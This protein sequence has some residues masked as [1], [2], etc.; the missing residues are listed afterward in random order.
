MKT[1]SQKIEEIASHEWIKVWTTKYSFLDVYQF[2]PGYTNQAYKNTGKG[3]DHILFNY[4]NGLAT[5][6]RIVSELKELSTFY[7]SMAVEDISYLEN[8]IQKMYEVIESI[9]SNYSKK[10]LFES[11]DTFKKLRDDLVNF[12]PYYL[13]M[14]WTPDGLKEMKIEDSAKEKITNLCL[15]ARHKTE[16]FYLNLEKF[17]TT[18]YELLDKEEQLGYGEYILALT[19]D[20]IEEYIN[21][22]KIVEKSILIERWNGAMLAGDGNVID[23]FTGKDA[24]LLLSKVESFDKALKEVKGTVAMKGIVRGVV[25]VIFKDE[26]M[27]KFNEGD[28]LI[29]T[30]TRP[31]WVPVMK[32]SGAFVTDAGGMLCHAAIV[33]RELGRPCVIG[34]KIATQVFKD[35]DM[36]EVDAERG[37]I[38]II[39]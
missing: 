33:A 32:K 21:N 12:L 7:A 18:S 25:K 31:E 22:K 8:S 14:L 34:T 37:L 17:V 35:G 11:I 30:M 26:D 24:E 5:V 13:V 2:V 4:K 6:Y 10:S 38:K 27:A 16:H 36:V 1:N 28:I 23:L 15:D 3:F 9:E 19:P 29:T 39:K 20:E